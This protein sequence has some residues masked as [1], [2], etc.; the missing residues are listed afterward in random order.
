MIMKSLLLSCL[1]PFSVLAVEVPV[2]VR[3]EEPEKIL[4][5]LNKYKETPVLKLQRDED[6]NYTISFNEKT[7]TWTF[8]AAVGG[9][10]C[11]LADGVGL[12]FP[13]NL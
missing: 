10:L 4:L 5:L 3:C 9:K 7:G 11:V 2:K 13:G 8:F 1:I 12:K 6:V